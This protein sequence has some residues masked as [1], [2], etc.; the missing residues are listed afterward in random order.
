MALVLLLEAANLL[1]LGG[2]LWLSHIQDQVAGLEEFAPGPAELTDLKAE[3]LIV[4][5]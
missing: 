5:H 3:H 4:L 2:L 1:L